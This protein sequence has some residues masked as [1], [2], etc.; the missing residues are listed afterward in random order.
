MRQLFCIA[1]AASM[2]SSISSKSLF[3]QLSAS[4]SSATMAPTTMQGPSQTSSKTQ[5][6]CSEPWKSS[7]RSDII[8]MELPCVLVR[9]SKQVV[10]RVD[11]L[12]YALC[13]VEDTRE[14][15]ALP[16]CFRV[17]ASREDAAAFLQELEVV[18]ASRDD[19]AALLQELDVPE[20]ERIPT[21][22]VALRGRGLP[23]HSGTALTRPSAQRDQRTPVQRESRVRITISPVPRI[24]SSSKASRKVRS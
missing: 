1:S 14:L 8:L 7:T 23:A 2:G 21:A 16:F 17:D 10:Q 19:A 11:D 24:S 4:F 13:L 15:G 12:V 20:R 22:H 6:R 5:H 18:D 3:S 9:V